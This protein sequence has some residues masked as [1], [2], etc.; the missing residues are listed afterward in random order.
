[1]SSTSRIRGLGWTIPVLAALVLALGAPASADRAL[2]SALLRVTQDHL[3]AYDREDVE[4]TLKTV[5]KSSP[6]YDTTQ[7]LLAAQFPEQD[8]DVELVEFRYIGHD[9]EFAYARIK[10]KYVAEGDEFAD[11]VI[12]ALFLFHHEN[13]AWKFW[14]QHIIGVEMMD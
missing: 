12:D 3:S 11:N 2:E 8:V 13:G 4:A 5:H 6:Q 14:S 7:K 9:D 10:T 1:M